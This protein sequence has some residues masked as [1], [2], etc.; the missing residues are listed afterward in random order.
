MPAPKKYP[1][2][3]RERSVR[4]VL[5]LVEGEEQASVTGACSRVGQQ[6]GVNRDTLRGWVKQAQIDAGS[7]QA[8]QRAH[9]LGRTQPPLN[10]GPLQSS[11]TEQGWRASSSKIARRLGSLNRPSPPSSFVDTKGQSTRTVSRYELCRG[12]FAPAGGARPVLPACGREL[13]RRTARA[14]YCSNEISLML[15]VSDAP[16]R[17][18]PRAS[19]PARR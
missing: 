7:Q 10:P 3:M 8:T 19:R 4:L 6:L 16:D 13:G 1:E 14:G 9:A 12:M 5:D 15:L 17:G 18:S 11:C 2:E